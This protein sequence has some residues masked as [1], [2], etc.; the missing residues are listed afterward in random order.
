MAKVDLAAD[1]CLVAG[2]SVASVASVASAEVAAGEVRAEC[3]FSAIVLFRQTFI[4][5]DAFR[6][7]RIV[8]EAGRTNAVISSGVVGAR[9]A[10]V[11]NYSLALVDVLA[12]SVVSSV[13]LV[14]RGAL[15]AVL[16]LVKVVDA[17]FSVEA[18]L[19]AADNLQL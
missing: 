11:A 17:L 3:G 18:V 7:Q 14:A 1:G 16:V 13:R 19:R 9:K 4:D 6:G 2:S 12:S 5:I 8:L 10:L 15:A